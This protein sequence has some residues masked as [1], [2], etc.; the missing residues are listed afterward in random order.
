[1][2]G[3]KGRG[4]LVAAVVWMAAAV[5]LVGCA[6]LPASVASPQAPE[7]MR[8]V[9]V[10]ADPAELALTRLDMPAGFEL[11]AE[12]GSDIEYVALYLRQSALDTDTSGGNTLLSVMTSVG[13]Y[14]TTV[15]AEQAFLLAERDAAE[16]ELEAEAL[17]SRNA[18]DIVSAPFAGAAV[19]TDAS[20]ALRVTYRLMD[21]TVVEYGHRFRLGNVLAHVVVAAIGNP[22]EPETLLGDAR[23]L[24]QRQIDHIVEAAGD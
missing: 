21:R 18:T 12:K 23:D 5:A 4:R 8:G 11:A 22:N 2:N 19:G 13:V 3:M 9:V 15:D 14:T 20:E 1:M 10:E 16:E 24:V 6:P 7:A 17:V